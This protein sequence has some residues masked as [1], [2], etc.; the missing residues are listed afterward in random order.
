MAAQVYVE[1]EVHAELEELWRLTQDASQH[2]RW[3]LRF[4]DIVPIGTGAEDHARFRY[5]TRLL[6]FLRIS[7]VGVHAGE[8]RRPDGG[9]TSA[10][11]FAS[12][13]PLSV[14]DEG[15]G[16]WRYLPH[17][18]VVRFATGY[19]YRPRWGALGRVVDA[20]I[21]RP[22]MRWATA[23]SFDRLRIWAE[24]DLS[25]EAARDRALLTVGAR[26][27]AAAAAFLVHPALG[28]AVTVAALVLPP[29]RSVPAARRCRRRPSPDIRTPR[30]ADG[31]ASKELR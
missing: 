9:C 20:T 16:Y 29:S 2:R 10:L 8:R 31:L 3:D 23:W 12:D 1:M 22:I 21:V 15:S 4:S 27:T 13:H 7:G 25:P 17:G 26:A 5:S 30:I 19:D 14:I 18:E 6:P 24:T 11:M 28:L